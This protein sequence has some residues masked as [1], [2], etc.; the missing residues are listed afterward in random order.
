MNM[1]WFWY[2]SLVLLA[3]CS[4]SPSDPPAELVLDTEEP[5]EDY[6]LDSTFDWGDF[7]EGDFEEYV[8]PSYNPSRQ[9]FV[10]LIHTKIEANLNWEDSQLNGIATISMTPHF[11]TIDSVVLDAKGME[12]KSVTQAGRELSYDYS[13]GN[14]LIVYLGKSY[15]KD[16]LIT[17][18]IDYIAKPEERETSGSAAITSDKG[19]YF[20]NPKGKEEGKM[21]QVW[22]QGETEA[23]SV[24]FPTIDAPNMKSS[25]ELLLTVDNKYTTLS[26]GKL[27]SSKKNTDGT[28]TDYWKQDLPHAPYLFML[29]V[30]EFKVVKDSYTRGDGKKIEVNYYVEAEYE[31]DAQAIFGKTPKMIKF[32]SN[33]LGVEYPWDKY[34][35]IVVRDYVSGAMENTGAV[36]FGDYVYKTKRELIDGNDESTIAHELFHHWF[37][38]LVTCESWAN[39][40]LNESFANYSQYLWDEYEYGI[41]EADYNAIDEANGYYQ[42]EGYHDLI[43]FYYDDKEEM[44]DGHSYN[45]GGRI[46]HMLRNH[47][48]DDAFFQGLNKY[49]TTNAYKSAEVH[50]LRLAMEEVSGE[51]LNWFFNQWFLGKGHPV[52]FTEQEINQEQQTV[53]LRIQQAQSFDVFRLPLKIALWDDAGKH[54]YSVVLDSTNQQFTFPFQGKIANVLLDEEQMLLA[55]VYEEKPTAQYI[56]QCNNADKFRA[57]ST[58]LKHI[59]KSTDPEKT[60]VLIN[61][62]NAKFWGIRAEALNYLKDVEDAAKQGSYKPTLKKII[63]NDPKSKVRNAAVSAL[64]SLDKNEAIA[65]IRKVLKQDS[66]LMVLGNALNELKEIDTVQALALARELSSAEE[67]ELQVGAAE[68]M[69]EYGNTQ[70]LP[71]IENLI[72]STK[73]KNYNKLRTL[74]AYAYFVIRKGSDAME[75]SEDLLS[76]VKLNGNQY[77][78]WYYDRI[79]ERFMAIL[80]EES[81]QITAEIETLNPQKDNATILVLSNKKTKL[82]DLYNRLSVFVETEAIEEK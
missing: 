62:L 7:N 31:K 67:I 34:S 81:E 64:S 21:P 59:A 43:N 25:Q 14:V 49:L 60:N 3:S 17:L 58:A 74:L 38:D 79:V 53:T 2:I 6:Y 24:W 82:V 26:N 69:G 28:R 19:L 76:F 68:I 18:T 32:F 61:A 66:S 75:N 12:I 55:K 51:D 63:E 71:F 48:G 42:S 20:I 23:N 13:D 11:Y 70:D 65:I 46:L 36:I 72:K 35:E 4:V 8:E 52:I 15:K 27:I 33:K 50:N 41:D 30:G 40:P 56:H 73:V 44:F 29:A 57:K 45:K 47:L 78:G 5:N 77:T 39:L 16:E 80:G 22:T 10:D 37:G 1:K 9:R 54:S